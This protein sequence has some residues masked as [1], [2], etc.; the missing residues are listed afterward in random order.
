MGFSKGWKQGGHGVP[1]S[2][3]PGLGTRRHAEGG[4][5]PNNVST[6]NVKMI[7]YD[8]KK[9]K[10]TCGKREIDAYRL[11]CVGRAGPA[12]A[13]VAWGQSLLCLSSGSSWWSTW[14]EFGQMPGNEAEGG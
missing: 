9:K 14:P 5:D 3:G 11:W 6:L 10:E 7:K 4:G 8:L 13:G 12:K 2:T 1:R